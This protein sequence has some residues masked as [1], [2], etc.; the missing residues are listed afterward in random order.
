MV[1]VTS[2]R[3]GETEDGEKYVRLI[4]SGDLEMVRSET[5]GNY[6]A[7]TRR[8]SIA[9]TF[10]EESAKQMVGKELPGTIERINVEPYEYT[11]DNG[12]KIQISQRWIY[13]EEM[14]EKESSIREL[15]EATNKN[16]KS[17]AA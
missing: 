2:Y 12:E 14:V 11:L 17:K 5:T 8:A 6:Y 15:A 16:G 3:S 1:T 7:T 4:L 10:D 9:A 13:V